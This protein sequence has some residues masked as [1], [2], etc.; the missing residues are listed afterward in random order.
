M[1]LGLET[2]RLLLYRM[3]AHRTGKLPPRSRLTKLYP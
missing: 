3:A 1:R 2:S